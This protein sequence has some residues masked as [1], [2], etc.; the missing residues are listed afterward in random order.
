MMVSGF[1]AFAHGIFL[2]FNTLFQDNTVFGKNLKINQ[3][4]ELFQE[5]GGI[6]VGEKLFWA[7]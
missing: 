6:R 7:F 2:P 3:R 5:I 1:M 4:S